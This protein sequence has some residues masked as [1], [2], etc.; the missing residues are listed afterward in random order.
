M[1]L[2]IGPLTRFA[3]DCTFHSDSTPMASHSLQ[4]RS[5]SK[6]SAKPGSGLS[7]V[8]ITVKEPEVV[9]QIQMQEFER[10]L[11]RSGRSPA[12]GAKRSELRRELGL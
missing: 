1:Q 3:G 2:S 5:H 12:D 4:K 8:T 9:R 11:K 10:W 7:P 6:T